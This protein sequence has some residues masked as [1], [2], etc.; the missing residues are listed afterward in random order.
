[1]T[2][3]CLS[4]EIT[5]G[6]G[7][8]G[9]EISAT[10]LVGSGTDYSDLVSTTQKRFMTSSIFFSCNLPIRKQGK[11]TSDLF[12]NWGFNPYFAD[13]SK[14]TGFWTTVLTG[15]LLTALD[16]CEIAATSI[17]FSIEAS[18]TF[19]ASGF[20]V[21]ERIAATSILFCIIGSAAFGVSGFSCLAKVSGLK[22][23]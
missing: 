23:I 21:L 4:V 17:F 14:I 13:I 18:G 16:P 2:D 15:S 7:T 9:I 12:T 5:W 20:S 3:G 10:N 1:M 19:G 22:V 11:L 8:S 6:C